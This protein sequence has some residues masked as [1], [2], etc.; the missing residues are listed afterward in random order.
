MTAPNLNAAGQANPRLFW[1]G[2]LLY[3]VCWTLI[4]TLSQSNLPL[5]TIEGL[6]WGHGWQ[7][8]FY[9]HPPLQA[10]LLEVVSHISFHASLGY[11]GLSALCGGITL[12]AV[13]HTGLLF[14]TPPKA[15]LATAM[16]ATLPYLTFLIPEFNPNVLSLALW[17]LAGY[18]FAAGLLKQKTSYW[19]ALGMVFALGFYAKYSIALLAIS[20]TAF[21]LRQAETRVWFSRPHPYGAACIGILLLM[22]HLQWLAAHHFLPFAYALSR[23]ETT[24]GFYT[25]LTS[26]GGFLLA[27]LVTLIP[28]LLLFATIREKGRA[29]MP[30]ISS[31]LLAWLA[32][33]PT[34]LTLVAALLTQ[35]HPRDMWGMP[36]LSFIPLWLVVRYKTSTASNLFYRLWLGLFSLAGLGF[37]INQAV[38][39]E[40]PLRGQFPGRLL[41][42][43]VA[44]IWQEHEGDVP[45]TTIV[46]D[47]W[48]GGNAAFYNPNL[49]NR[50][51]LW[52]DGNASISP[53]I[54]PETI[55]RTGILLLWPEGTSP[56]LANAPAFKGHLILPWQVTHTLTGQPIPPVSLNWAI[57]PPYTKGLKF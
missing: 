38:V 43:S 3:V 30:S 20:F 10:F 39:F 40:K 37:A 45:L 41:A 29:E 47:S 25:T 35:H 18:F 53:W 57:L 22:P 31:R 46:S 33:A 19:A 55:R 34:L 42:Q 48:L 52:L 12:W 36:Y 49:A 54:N 1:L 17:A 16:T 23:A 50:P 24:N 5:D 4:P 2:L 28:V 51:Q 11:F 21:L 27:Q 8:G 14:T 6:A 44:R 26:A 7:W 13:Y 32:F 56:P 9:K 15:L